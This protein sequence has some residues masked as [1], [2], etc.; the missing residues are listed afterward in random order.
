MSIGAL[1]L[2]AF[3]CFV[4][5]LHVTGMGS[6]A[7]TCWEMDLWYEQIAKKSIKQHLSALCC[8]CSQK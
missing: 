2:T 7:S 8:L 4:S 6:A 5:F 3:F 1:L